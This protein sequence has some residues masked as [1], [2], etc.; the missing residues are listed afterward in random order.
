M[1]RTLSLLL[2]LVLA[3]SVL[4]LGLTAAAED[5]GIE[6]LKISPYG[7]DADAP[8]T[9]S[10]YTAGGASFLFLPAETDPAA[11]KVWFTASGDVTLDG[12][13]LTNGGSAAAF[14]AGTHTLACGDRT[15]PLTVCGAS[16]IPK[17]YLTTQ[18]GSLSYIHQSKN[19]KEPGTIRIYENGALTLDK[20]LK[21]IKGRGNATWNYPKKPYNIKFDK[22]TAVLGMPKAKKWT[23]LAGHYHDNALMKNRFALDFGRLIGL[24]ETSEC[25]SV[26]LYVNGEYLG[27]YLI[28]E[29]VEVGEN[30][31]D[32]TDLDK[33]N[34]NANPDAGDLEALPQC[35][36]RSG[37]VPG[38]MKWID[39]PNSPEDIS[40]GYL[41][42][43]DY[44][45]RYHAEPSG[46]VSNVGMP[47]VVGS[48]EYAS[49]SEVEYISALWNAA[50]EA[51][52]SPTGYNAAGKHFTECF[53]MDS[54]VKCYLAEEFTKDVD[55]GITSF[56]F[57]KKAGD[58]KF[59][60][61]PL[62][63]FDHALGSGTT[64]GNRLTVFEPDTWYA[65]QLHRN[66]I[67]TACS[68]FPTFFAQCYS[69]PVFRAAVTAQWP[70]AAAAFEETAL[71][72]LTAGLEVLHAS[73]VM[74]HLRWNTYQSTDVATVSAKS[75]QD[76]N[77]LVAF[78]TNRAPALS[79]G[80]A[81]DGA[82][83]VYDG[84]GGSGRTLY[85]AKIYS[86]GETAAA[87]ENVTYTRDGF[88][89]AGWNTKADGS[90][91]AVAANE[92]FTLTENYTVLYAQWE[93]VPPEE[94]QEPDTPAQPDSGK[95]LNFFQRFW[96]WL[97]NL[98]KKIF[99]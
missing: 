70:Q 78:L 92:T 71:P 21:Q 11:A 15:Y 45:N 81:A 18:S 98:F 85:D 20:D 50:E 12:D 42:E 94:P 55:S 5:A 97:K 6:T 68:N 13:V 88:S 16:D 82:T 23:L 62:W 38:S 63:D 46:F 73:A 44:L 77:A 27:V 32:I 90:G 58:D 47:I 61:G 95:K 4:S 29:S 24:D 86:V 60:A 28:C 22:K 40:G 96:K 65:N 93:A 91:A 49:R 37:Y 8:D 41:L 67:D 57:Y 30:R 99:G 3:L 89:F 1:K 26:D 69:F 52:Y 84:N 51:L 10:W 14:T 72:A 75:V 19:N 31:V 66:S 64:I 36:V 79:K 83:V 74:N 35:G 2:A 25:R 87:R 59:Y 7:G 39:I 53:D 9:V 76:A 48:P 54:L 34:E 17:V 56:Y 80:F 43:V 33:A